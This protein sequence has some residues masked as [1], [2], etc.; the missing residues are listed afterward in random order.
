MRVRTASVRTPASCPA[1]T[2]DCASCPASSTVFM[3][4]P[5]PTFTSS[6]RP[7]MPSASFLLMIDA[8]ISGMLSTVAVTSRRRYRRR[9]AGAISLVWPT[10]THPT[11]A[12]ASTISRAA[13]STR[14]PAI[15]SSLSSV[16]PVCPSPRPDIIGTAAPH[17][18]ARGAST[19]EV[20][21]PTPPVLCLSTFRPASPRRSKRVPEWAI[22]SVSQA[23]SSSP[24]PRRTIAISKAEI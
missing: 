5:H 23:V 1:R 19:S 9:S 13:R 4:A 8:V 15:D 14:N 6:T 17:A 18:A 20:L 2:I 16:P 22:A 12:R 21:S 24:M 11:S 10:M 3:N 7:S